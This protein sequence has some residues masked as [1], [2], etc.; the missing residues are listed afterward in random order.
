MHLFVVEEFEEHTIKPGYQ[1]SILA[2]L[3]SY[4]SEK[5]SDIY[6]HA[7]KNRTERGK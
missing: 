7:L 5:P 1:D 6:I 4:V 3:V 2:A